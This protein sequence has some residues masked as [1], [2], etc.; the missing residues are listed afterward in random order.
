MIDS[1]AHLCDSRFNESRDDIVRN[2]KSVGLKAIIEVGADMIS[3]RNAVELAS[4]SSGVFALVGSH[5]DDSLS[6]SVEHIN[7][8]RQL[9]KCDKV[10]GIGE[11]GLDY[12]YGKDTISQQKKA[13]AMQLELASELDLPVA[14]HV[15]DAYSDAY[16]M[17]SEFRQSCKQKILLHCYSSSAEMVQ[18]FNKFDCYYALGGVVTF[19]NAK[20]EDVIKAIP[21]ERLLVE[22][23]CPYMT[24]A[25]HRGE[26]NEPSFV[27]YVLK[28]IAE[29]LQVTFE[30]VEKITEDNT[31]SLF[32]K[33]DIL[34]K[35]Y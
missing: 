21:K 34:S 31:L 6:F 4:K 35:K 14:L 32:S 18:R 29:V 26:L 10:V 11:I 9:A 19:K 17:L 1:H 33:M 20:K 23:D 8:Y 13:F 30:E 22:T 24:P 12:Y 25:P 16:D 7:E 27:S 28:K 5:P 15:R 2:M 3:S